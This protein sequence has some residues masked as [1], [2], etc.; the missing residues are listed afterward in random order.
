M[1]V[2]GTIVRFF[3][4]GGLFMYPIVI[5]LAIG[6]SIAIERY[7]YLTRSEAGNR[8]LW[9][10]LQPLLSNGD[11]AG[12]FEVSSKSEAA[13]GQV[14]AYGISRMRTSSDRQ[15]VEMSMEES[16]LEVTP[17]LEKRTHYLAVLANVATLLG[18]LGTI[19]GLIQ[20]FTAVANVNPA[21]KADLLSA[22]ISVAMNT[23]AFGLMVA[24]PLLLLHAV[25]QTRTTAL[26]DSIEMA[27]VKFLNTT[28]TTENA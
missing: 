12:A 6:L 13:V 1:E 2:F 22:S 21:E 17:Q 27:S 4:N 16:L 8:K 26:V 10:K 11:Y 5:I 3:Q 7:I 25:L 23:T 14:L 9:E 18:L 20:G 19:I 24:I 15:D 28:R